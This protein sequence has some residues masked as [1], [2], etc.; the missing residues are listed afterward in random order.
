MHT[1]HSLLIT[2]TLYFTHHPPIIFMYMMAMYGPCDSILISSGY[3]VVVRVL[4]LCCRTRSMCTWFWSYAQASYCQTFSS[5]YILHRPEPQSCHVRDDRSLS[6]KPMLHGLSSEI[7]SPCCM[8]CQVRSEAHV[9]W[10][11][12]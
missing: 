5:S 7:G 4:T 12:K 6:R 3:G 10:I 11:V 8:D 9:A 1:A 2:F